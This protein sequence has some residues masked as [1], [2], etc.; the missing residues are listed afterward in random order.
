MF[1]FKRKYVWKIFV[2]DYD[3]SGNK[4]SIEHHHQWDDKVRAISGGLTIFKTAKGQWVNIEGKLYS[5]KV[6][7][8]EIYCTKKDISNIVDITIKHY[9]QEAVYVHRSSNK[10]ILRYAKK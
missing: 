10:A 7:P 3:N 5:E 8:V 1:G 9:T 4:Y 2:P 6:I